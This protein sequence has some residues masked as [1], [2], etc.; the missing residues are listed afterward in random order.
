MNNHQ[1]SAVD[2]ERHRRT[3]G[4]PATWSKV[5]ESTKPANI[6]D[7]GAARNWKRIPKSSK[8]NWKSYPNQGCVADA[9][10]NR[11]GAVLE[12][13]MV[14]FG[15][16]NHKNVTGTVPGIDP[17]PIKT[18][19]KIPKTAPKINPGSMKNRGCV[20]DAFLERFGAA[21]GRQNVG[22]SYKSGVHFGYPFSS[23]IKKMTSKKA[24]KNR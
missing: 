11:F 14:D 9:F 22:T 3:P 1:K 7:A 13:P 15:S 17:K 24:S 5:I 2:A 8:Y 21:H 10:F 23:K 6:G 16:Q 4:A 12:C 20:A 18:F 19:N